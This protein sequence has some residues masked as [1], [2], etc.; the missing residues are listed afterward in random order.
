MHMA[1]YILVIFVVC[2]TKG[3]KLNVYPKPIME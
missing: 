2:M 1:S 3:K